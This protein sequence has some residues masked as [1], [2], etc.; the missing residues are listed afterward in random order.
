MSGA[1]AIVVG[2]SEVEDASGLSTSA[3]S[4]ALLLIT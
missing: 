4:P 1:A 2:A 3:C